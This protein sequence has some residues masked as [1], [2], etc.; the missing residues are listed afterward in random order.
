MA[1]FGAVGHQPHTTYKKTTRIWGDTSKVIR[2]V[3]SSLATFWFGNKTSAISGSVL[4]NGAAVSRLVRAY[5]RDTGELIGSVT[6]SA[7]AGG[8]F[9][10]QLNGYSGQVYVIAFD[11]NVLPNYNAQIYDMVV[12]V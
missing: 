3:S 2:A 7:G 4:E 11:D 5:R 6:S 1:D 9:T 8:A 10:I 12:P